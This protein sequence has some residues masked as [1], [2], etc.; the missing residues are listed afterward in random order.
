M[1]LAGGSERIKVA[2]FCSLKI[3][4]D[5]RDYARAHRIEDVD[6]AIAEGMKEKSR[7]FVEEGG[8]IYRE[9]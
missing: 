2:H 1:L 3:T 9:V 5:V 6:A 8:N 7:E 4:Q